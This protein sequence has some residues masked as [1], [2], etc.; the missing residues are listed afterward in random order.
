MVSQAS[1]ALAW[2][3]SLLLELRSCKPRGMVKK[4]KQ[5]Q[6]NIEKRILLGDKQE[7]LKHKRAQC[8]QFAYKKVQKQ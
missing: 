8:Y 4:N 3:Q 6:N 7:V 5:Q 1:S 2:V